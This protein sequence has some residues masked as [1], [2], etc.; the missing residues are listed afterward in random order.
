VVELVRKNLKSRDGTRWGIFINVRRGSG[1]G[2][3]KIRQKVRILDRIIIY[4]P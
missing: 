4:C 2:M 1:G 3:P